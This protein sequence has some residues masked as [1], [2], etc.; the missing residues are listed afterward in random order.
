MFCGTLNSQGLD[1]LLRRTGGWDD[2][3]IRM[4]SKLQ[5]IS[6]LV[7]YPLEHLL[8]ADRSI[9]AWFKMS[10]QRSDLVSRVWVSPLPPTQQVKSLD[11]TRIAAAQIMHILVS[12]DPH[13]GVRHKTSL[14][15]A[16][17]HRVGLSPAPRASLP[18]QMPTPS[19]PSCRTALR[20]KGALSPAHERVLAKKRLD[21]KFMLA[22]M[23]FY[24]FNAVHWTLP[25]D[26]TY[27]GTGLPSR[28]LVSLFGFLEAFTGWIGVLLGFH[29]SRPLA[30]GPV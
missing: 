20:S 29:S 13:R 24:L 4:C 27:L 11:L 15:R 5:S 16:F 3:R 2:P 25:G 26:A 28:Q 30:S 18:P 7:Y 12:M 6:M 19:P 1:P 10:L 23:V 17:P 9:P 21:L 8:W 22:R 14:R